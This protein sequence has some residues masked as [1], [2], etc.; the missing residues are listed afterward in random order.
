MHGAQGRG[1]F[2]VL[3]FAARATWTS[4][5]GDVDGAL[6]RTD[7]TIDASEADSVVV[8]ST[9]LSVS[10]LPTGTV[11][12]IVTAPGT[13]PELLTGSAA[14]E[15]T[16]LLALHLEQYPVLRVTVDGTVLDIAILR[17]SR[18]EYAIE[19]PESAVQE[20]ESDQ[21][22]LVVLEWARNFPRALVLCDSAGSAILSIDPGIHARGFHFTAYLRW[23]GFRHRGHDIALPEADSAVG[24]LIAAAREQLRPHFKAGSAERTVEVLQS[25]RNEGAYPCTEPAQSELDVA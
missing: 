8:E 22:S 16:G 24:V 17:L 7:A 9:R 20:G 23:E 10:V 12:T 11:V 15:L 18:R 21:A 2:F 1:R 13:T 3:S 6:W 25:W 19:V 14:D 5:W 4:H